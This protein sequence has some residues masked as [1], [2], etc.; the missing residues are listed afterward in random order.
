M[1]KIILEPEPKLLDVG[2]GTRV[3]TLDAWSWN[4]SQS[5][6]FELRLHRPGD[7]LERR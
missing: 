1:E 7:R 2:A 4:Q 5:L 3:K 6:K